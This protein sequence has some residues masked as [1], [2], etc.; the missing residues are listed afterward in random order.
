MNE[1]QQLIAAAYKA[2]N[3]RDLEAALALMHQEV[4]WPNGMEGGR[5]VGVA[6]V[7]DYWTRQ[8]GMINPHVE[9]VSM[10]ENGSG[11]I[12]V[13]VHQVVRDLA[14]DILS[15]QIVH[16]IYTLRDGEILR[17]DI[18]NAPQT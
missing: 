13:R 16:H 10:E 1:N 15:D 14:G 2:F 17:M 4:D 9:P 3:T 11:Q 5:V 6:G 8:W 18:L 12:D 7:H